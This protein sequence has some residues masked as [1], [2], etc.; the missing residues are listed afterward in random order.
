MIILITGD[1]L[2][3]PRPEK[4]KSFKPSITKKMLISYADTYSYLLQ[5]NLQEKHSNHNF[6]VINRCQRLSTIKSVE[7][8]FS[9]HLFFFQPDIIVMQVGIVDCWFREKFNGKQYIDIDKF[10]VYYN[11]IISK[12][13]LRP[14]TL[15]I[16]IGI[17][18]TSLEMNK[19]YPG[20]LVEIKKYNNVLKSNADNKQIFYIDMEKNIDPAN[21]FK[22]LHYDHH[23]LNKEGNILVAQE[24]EVII[25]KL[26]NLK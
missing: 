14:E 24:L 18:P 6:Y 10:K 1:S 19:R 26:L 12:L 21:P 7:K 4:I 15:F 2:G 11:K 17:C 5:K 16:I 8:T 23:H 22:Y 25:D 13:K 20:I 3:L 9:D